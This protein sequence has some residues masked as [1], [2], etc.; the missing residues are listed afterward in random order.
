M[1]LFGLFHWCSDETFMLLSVLSMLPGLRVW[2]AK[3]KQSRKAR[4]ALPA[5]DC[6]H[7]DHA[8]E[9]SAPTE[10]ASTYY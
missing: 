3:W 10:G 6:C 5:C 7:E 2:Y 8:T 4:H 1:N 9:R